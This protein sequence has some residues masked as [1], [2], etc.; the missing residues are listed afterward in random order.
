MLE[1]NNSTIE[2]MHLQHAT[3]H[4]NNLPMSFEFWLKWHLSKR[5]EEGEF[6]GSR[7]TKKGKK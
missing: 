6:T 2:I 4:N 3:N 1:K 7:P 5:K